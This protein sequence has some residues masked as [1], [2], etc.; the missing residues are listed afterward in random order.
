MVVVIATVVIR[1]D[2]DR[3]LLVKENGLW[4]IPGGKVEKG[5]RVIEAAEREIRE[6]TG[7]LTIIMSLARIYEL[8]K[9]DN[10]HLFFVFKARIGEKQGEGIRGCAWFHL[11]EIKSL[12]AYPETYPLLKGLEKESPDPAEYPFKIHFYL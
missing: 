3:V 1:D 9:E 5:E 8:R 7:Y 11:E 10:Y 12:N 4:A 2:E 6:E